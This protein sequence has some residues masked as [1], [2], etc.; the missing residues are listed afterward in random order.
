MKFQKSI[1]VA[2]TRIN[3]GTFWRKITVTSSHIK[4]ATKLA[5]TQAATGD[6]AIVQAIVKTDA[7]G[8]ASGTNFIIGSTNAKGLVNI[9]VETVANLGANITKNLSAGHTTG[10]LT[11][12]NANPTVTANLTV[13]EAGQN[14]WV[15]SSSADCTGAGTIDIYVQFERITDNGDVLMVG[16]T[17]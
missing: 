7:T 6:L 2:V 17:A 9:F 8:L 13:L 4:T 1:A 14:L 12:G 11:T 16:S 10:D 15:N 5:I 3:G